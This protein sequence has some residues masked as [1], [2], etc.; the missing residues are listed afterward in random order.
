MSHPL[1]AATERMDRGATLPTMT[2]FKKLLLAR[3]R[4]A[5][6]IPPVWERRDDYF[7][8]ARRWSAN[9]PG[10]RGIHMA[11]LLSADS[12][13]M[14]ETMLMVMVHQALCAIMGPGESHQRLFSMTK[15]P[16]SR[17]SSPLVAAACVSPLR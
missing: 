15:P 9:D 14:A 2:A 7:I 5:K 13:V 6:N 16:L 17:A 1:I 12:A 8:F 11:A 4:A 10:L 3:Q